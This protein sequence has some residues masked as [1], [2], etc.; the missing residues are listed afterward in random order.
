MS[1]EK[2]INVVSIEAIVSVAE[3]AIHLD[4][5]LFFQNVPVLLV[6][7]VFIIIFSVVSRAGVTT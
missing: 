1:G 2:V 5:A 7:P 4:G 6:V 3:L